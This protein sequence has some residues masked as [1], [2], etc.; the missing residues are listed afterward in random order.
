MVSFV[1]SDEGVRV[2]LTL[3]QQFFLKILADH[4]HRQ[5]TYTP[6]GLD[7]M[8]IMRYAKSHQVE[9]IVWYQCRS[10]LSTKL[11]L[12]KIRKRLETASLAEVF[13]FGNNQQALQELEYTFRNQKIQC[14]ILKGLSVAGLYP[15]PAYRTMGDMDIVVHKNDLNHIQD[16]MYQ[17]GYQR[18]QGERV[19]SYYRGLTKVEVHHQLVNEQNL[20]TARRRTFFNHVWD[21]VCE[22]D[23]NYCLDWNFH[24]LF[25]VEHTKQHFSA[26]GVG[27][28]QF[29]DIAVAVMNKLDLDWKWIRRELDKIDLWDFAVNVFGFCKKWWDVELPFEVAE[30]DEAFFEQS[31]EFVFQNGVFGHDNNNSNIHIVEKQMRVSAS[32]KAFR[33]IEIAIKRICIPYSQLLTLPYCAFVRN[34]RHL[35]PLAWMYR[36]IYVAIHKKGNIIKV[37]REIFMSGEIIR[38]HE[39]LMDR[40]GV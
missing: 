16:I 13:Y 29:L 3:E 12:E 19:Q 10:Y 2:I 27:F 34:R 35:V 6:E 9:G 30:P 40:W 22:E 36:V 14:I 11:E 21:Y 17:L 8:E 31:T 33:A 15:I 26:N 1:N 7:W 4:I 38:T 32:P 37:L 18:Q 28:R 39:K 24:F 5:A 25:L 20:E 23:G